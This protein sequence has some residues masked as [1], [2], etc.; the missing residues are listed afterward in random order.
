MIAG[1]L[2]VFHN[3]Y[4][5]KGQFQR[6]GKEK[7]DPSLS[8]IFP[9]VNGI[10]RSGFKMLQELGIRNKG[11]QRDQSVDDGKSRTDEDQTKNMSGQVGGQ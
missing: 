5:N 7:S 8:E 2:K 1:W 11:S 3:I 4:A 6:K 9:A 10:V